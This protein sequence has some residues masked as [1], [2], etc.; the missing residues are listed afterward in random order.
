MEQV[1]RRTGQNETRWLNPITCD[2]AFFIRGGRKQR[3]KQERLFSFKFRHKKALDNHRLLYPTL[4]YTYLQTARDIIKCCAQFAVGA[5]KQEQPRTCFSNISTYGAFRRGIC[6]PLISSSKWEHISRS[7]GNVS[8]LSFFLA[9]RSH[10]SCLS[11][12]NG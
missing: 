8:L 7:T 5:S 3:K 11:K 4:Q 2:K 1:E 10:R 12:V 6:C 9:T